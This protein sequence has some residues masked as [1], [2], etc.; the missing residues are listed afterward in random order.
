MD[1]VIV[2]EGVS[3]RLQRLNRNRPTT[4]QEAVIRG[5][6]GGVSE[7]DF[8]A[9]KDV[10]FRVGAGKSLGIIGGN[11]A[12]K[13]TLMR[14]IARVGKPTEGRMT[15]NGRISPL[16]ELGSGFHHELTGRENV[17]INGV[18]SGLTR[19]EVRNRFDDIVSF[20]ELEHAIDS[21]LRTYSSGMYMRLAFAIA[22]HTDPDIMLVDEVLAVGDVA[23]QK[24][25]LNQIDHFKRSGATLVIVSHEPELMSE[26]CD[27]VLWLKQGV[28]MGYGPPEKVVEGYLADMMQG[29]DE[30]AEDDENEEEDETD[31]R[32]GTKE[33]EITGVKL[34]NNEGQPTSRIMIGDPLSVEIAYKVNKPVMNPR[35]LISILNEKDEIV[36]T[37]HTEDEEIADGR[38]DE[39]GK[40]TARLG[41]IDLVGAVYY[42]DAGAFESKWAHN[43]DYHY[44]AR[45]FTVG[46]EREQE[47]IVRPP[48]TW[49]KRLDIKQHTPRKTR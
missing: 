31:E 49:K 33:I 3:K 4:L 28:V 46:P 34:L 40:I 10:D 42:V 20:A 16:L 44:H 24:K 48:V 23:F 35:F 25:C 15:V 43:Y 2:A 38:F 6:R 22:M 26:L 37:V 36:V 11:G 30:E 13:S 8:W 32:S 12:G 47:G 45:R 39:P 1:D 17:Y 29:Y 41:R 9:L 21:P 19:K 5:M 18:I 14:L 27:Q 7:S